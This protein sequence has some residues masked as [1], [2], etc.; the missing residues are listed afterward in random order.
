MRIFFRRDEV[1]LLRRW[2]ILVNLHF[3]I[4]SL[5]EREENQFYFTKDVHVIN[6]KERSN[7]R[8]ENPFFNITTAVNVVG[9]ERININEF[10][11]NVVSGF[12]L[13]CIFI[14]LGITKLVRKAAT[15]GLLL[16]IRI[17]SCEE[18]ISAHGIIIC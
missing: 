1:L 13:V 11:G 15:L 4:A 14:N 17:E 6:I 18:V 12:H 10:G 5:E 3:P 7:I 9:N 16:F 2:T 8:I